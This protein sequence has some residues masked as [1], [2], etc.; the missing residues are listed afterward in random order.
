MYSTSCWFA[1]VRVAASC[2]WLDDQA[3]VSTTNATQADG[4]ATYCI[5]SCDTDMW[6]PAE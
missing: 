3:Y 1:A 5:A 4:V 2:N 6:Q